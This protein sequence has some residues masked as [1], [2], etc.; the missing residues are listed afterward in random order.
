MLPHP[1]IK[2]KT[3]ILLLLFLSP[4]SSLLARMPETLVDETP[5]EYWQFMFFYD[6]YSAPGQDEFTLRLPLPFY[7]RYKN[8]EKGYTFQHSLYPIF[9]SHGTNYWNKWTF[10]YFF[11]GDDYYHTDTGKDTD[12]N[13]GHILFWGRG[14][15]EKERYFG[16]WPLYGS[17]KDKLAQNEVNFVLWPVYM[18]WRT[19]EYQATGIIWPLIMWGDSPVRNDLRIFPFYS[20]KI[21]EGKYDKRT[22]LWPFVQ[23]GEEDLNK[24]DP[25]HNY[26]FWPFYGRKYSESGE[27]SVHGVGP[28]LLTMP[29]VSWGEDT[30]TNAYS[31]NIFWFL[32]QY[33][34]SDDPYMRKH[35]IFPFYGRYNFGSREATFI[36]PFYVNLKTH[37]NI[38]EAETNAFMAIVPLYW[39]TDR[40]YLKDWKKTTYL[41]MWPFFHYI[42]DNRG[43]FEFRSL[44]LWPAGRSDKFER[45][46]GPLYS[47]VEYRKFENGDKYFS[48][49]FRIYSQYWND[50]ELHL[51]L[52]G[53]E[54]H[55]T[56]RY[57]SA[58]I[59]GGFLGFRHDYS[60]P[61]RSNL[62][63]Q[64]SR[65]TL[66]L[67]WL[68]I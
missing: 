4:L 27:L 63:A 68:D 28:Y 11:T 37:S 20:H 33:S 7:G 17:W 60:L 61:A 26:L 64:E 31:F 14:D 5:R 39:K 49:M 41:K 45:Y 8:T 15:T 48:I 32:Y 30:K 44:A 18:S 46:W 9:Y 13:F 43:N 50:D 58:E 16:I 53:L 56:P 55:K 62:P 59:A 35:I 29:F 38:Y 57:W 6:S 3:L 34:R 54:F 40:Y 24:R 52:A 19:F 66:K 23:W 22:V 1:I 25:R 51:F 67:L 36:T 2:T 42:E 21:Y 47:L 10:L 12:F 65:N